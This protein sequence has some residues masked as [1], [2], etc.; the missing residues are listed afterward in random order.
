MLRTRVAAVL[1]GATLAVGGAASMALADSGSPSGGSTE[2]ETQLP[3]E[4]GPVTVDVAGVGTVTFT[5]DSTGAITDLVIT[6][7]DG[8]TVGDPVVTEEGIH[9]LVTAADGTVHVLE[10]S[11]KFEDGGIEVEV[12]TDTEDESDDAEG[13]HHGSDDS[14]DSEDGQGPSGSSGP[15]ADQPG[16]SDGGDSSGDGGGDSSDGGDSSG[17]ERGSSD[18]ND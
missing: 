13:D 18:G 17:G 16:E 9:I 8:V 12:E 11:A 6:P 7:I 10:I 4:G 5:V 1:F 14:G 2:T 3:I 15:S